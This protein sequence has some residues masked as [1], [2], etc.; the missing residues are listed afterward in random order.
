MQ[1]S[2][3]VVAQRFVGHKQLRG[4]TRRTEQGIKVL[5]VEP[6]VTGPLTAYMLAHVLGPVSDSPP[7][8]TRGFS[9]VWNL[10]ATHKS[11]DLE[12]IRIESR[13][14]LTLERLASLAS[15]YESRLA[16]IQ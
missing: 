16:R 2:R 5:P 4:K 13:K 7:I 10:L 1:H 12:T 6:L 11:A 9:P 3:S 8:P 14:A 15:L